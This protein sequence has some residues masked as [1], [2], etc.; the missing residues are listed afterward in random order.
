MSFIVAYSCYTSAG[1][2]VRPFMTALRDGRR[3]SKPLDM[4]QWRVKPQRALQGCA[5]PD[6]ATTTDHE[7]L[8]HVLRSS[9]ADLL[10]TNPSIIAATLCNARIGVIL[11]STKGAIEDVIWEYSE[12]ASIYPDVI[13]PLL[14]EFISATALAPVKR[15]VV[16][17]A[18]SSSHV[19]CFI[20][21][22]WLQT[23]SCDV[24]VV[25]ACDAIGAFI[26]NGFH[27]L[28]AL[29]A[30]HAE[31]FSAGRDGLTLGEAAACIVFSSANIT[32]EAPQMRAVETA[33]EGFAA[34]RADNEGS[35]LRACIKRFS[36]H[37]KPELIIAHGTGTPTNDAI[38]DRVYAG[39][40]GETVPITGTKWCVGHTMAASGAL[41]VIA[42][43][44][45]L[46]S[47]KN[48]AISNQAT[49]DPTLAATYLY[50]TERDLDAPINRVLVSSLGF[51]GVQAALLIEKADTKIPDVHLRQGY[52]GLGVTSAPASQVAMHHLHL[53]LPAVLELPTVM[54]T[55]VERWNQLDDAAKSL[56]LLA[57]EIKPRLPETKPPDLIILA[58]P[59]GSFATDLAFAKQHAISPS[60]FI[61]T[62][63]SVR[64]SA[65]LQALQWSG[66]VLCIQHPSKTLAT[67]V[68][69]GLSFTRSRG[70][71]THIY[72]YASSRITT[73]PS[74]AAFIEI[75]LS[76]FQPQTTVEQ[77]LQQD[78]SDH[79]FFS[80]IV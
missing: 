25:L 28:K 37:K 15:L 17:H 24:V 44:D 16:S 6:I 52:G 39:L 10:H 67:A 72:S 26:A 63:P 22:E 18:C 23:K 21:E 30:E 80:G 57:A 5:L 71:T 29:T 32:G 61:H 65:L 41:D 48:F 79:D 51:G 56:V 1:V 42:A 14:D 33:S 45:V 54:A 55:R 58:S 74:A 9:W 43:C 76:A 62:L 13:T 7:K 53:H 75:T 12:E 27:A 36:A 68:D 35:S 46:R 78:L 50:N 66:P 8:L 47:Q 59:E 77:F 20:A 19:A 2:G 64:G 70:W 34:T 4:K 31:P 73:G 49:I 11:A 60:K 40:Y 69:L 38:E 3:L